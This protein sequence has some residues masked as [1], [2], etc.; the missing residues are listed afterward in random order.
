MIVTPG[1]ATSPASQALEQFT[2]V[3]E[4]LFN[5]ALYL[6]VASQASRFF[7]DAVRNGALELLLVTPVTPPQIVR[8]QWTALWR[9]FAL[10]VLCVVLLQSAGTVI[11]VLETKNQ[12]AFSVATAAGTPA[13]PVRY[14]PPDMTWFLIATAVT[15]VIT[16]VASLVAVAWFGM[17]MGLTNRKTSLAVLKTVCFVLVLPW[18]ALIFARI[19][20]MFA[21]IPVGIG[22]SHT[23]M[24]VVPPLIVAVLTLAK[25]AF[26]ILWARWNLRANFRVQITGD[27]GHRSRSYRPEPPPSQPPAILPPVIPPAAGA[28]RL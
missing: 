10:P 11:S 16:S 21:M 9:T 6:W 24:L 14:I 17:W 27:R 28:F 23:A 4:W 8:G 20:I 15:G 2:T 22:G 3:L 26:F 12:I 7:V 18:I 19:F 5:L 1:A 25:D 13:A